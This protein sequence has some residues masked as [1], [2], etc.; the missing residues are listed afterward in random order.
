MNKEYLLTISDAHFGVEFEIK[1]LYGN[2]L[3]AY[4]PEIF[5]NRMW[6]LYNKVI[7]QIQKDHIQVL[8]IFELG[9]ALDGILRANSQLMQLRYG[10]IDSAILYADFL[11]TWLNELSN[12]VRIKFQW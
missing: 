9:D 11:S 1:D 12:H 4:S 5:K 2:I 3:N 7:E 10:I 8:N 6:D